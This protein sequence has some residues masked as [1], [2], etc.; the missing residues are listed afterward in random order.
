M[1]RYPISRAISRAQWLAELAT[2]LDEAERLLAQLIAE[3]VR[4]FDSELLRLRLVELRAELRRPGR[5][6]QTGGRII[7][8]AWPAQLGAP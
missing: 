7:G 5:I 3:G 2:A 8:S 6:G 1:N 4:P